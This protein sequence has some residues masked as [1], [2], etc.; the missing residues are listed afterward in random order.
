MSAAAVAAESCAVN[1]PCSSTQ[2]DDRPRQHDQPDRRRHVQ[3]QHH[4]QRVGDRAAHRRLVGFSGVPRQVGQ[5]GGGDRDPEEADRQVHQPE[6]ELQPGDG[7]FLLRRRQRRV[8]EDVDLDG[9]EAE[10]ARPHQPQDL[11]NVRVPEVERRPVTEPLAPERRPLHGDLGDA[12][13]D[14]GDRDPGDLRQ[15]EPRHRRHQ[16]EAGEDRRD[17]E[18][19][20]RQ[21]R[22]EEASQRVE[23]P[24]HRHG[25]RD[26]REEGHHDL[27]QPRRQLELALDVGEAGLRRTS[28]PSSCSGHDVRSPVVIRLVIG[29]AKRM[30][31]SDRTTVTRSSALMT[32]L[33]SRQAASRPR[34]FKRSRERRDEGGGHRAFGEEVADEVR[35]PEGDV[36]RVHGGAGGRAENPR[37]RRFTSDAEQPAAHR[38]DA[39][40]ARGAGQP[41]AHRGGAGRAETP[42]GAVEVVRMRTIGTPRVTEPKRGVQ[43][44]APASRQKPDGG[45]MRGLCVPFTSFRRTS[46]GKS[47]R[48]S[49]GVPACAATA[50][51][52]LNLASAGRSR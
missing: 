13:E 6:R 44:K 42:A 49:A 36:E 17:V 47:L 4:P 37:Q 39:D 5:R 51:G 15:A 28:K 2:L 40:H 21:R 7:A 24:H 3:H 50:N 20:R 38:G 29:A 10:R 9:G 14:R 8:D 22:D 33:P 35:H 45:W 31:R 41:G 26:G 52:R 12:A 1:L 16:R 46:G 30:P 34:L 23:H 11:A 25:N 48:H 19:R 18:H 32:R 27:R 43:K